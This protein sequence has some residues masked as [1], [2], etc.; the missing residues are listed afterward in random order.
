[1]ISNQMLTINIEC[2]NYVAYLYWTR[3]RHRRLDPYLSA[4]TSSCELGARLF[5]ID[6]IVYN[7]TYF[8][9]VE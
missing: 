3:W 5:N 4:T 9:S 6:D 2:S 1:M 8:R 7:L